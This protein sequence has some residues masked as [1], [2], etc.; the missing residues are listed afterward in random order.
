M[1]PTKTIV[2]SC[3]KTRK[4]EERNAIVSSKCKFCANEWMFY[5]ATKMAHHL[6]SKCKN[7]PNDIKS[8]LAASQGSSTSKS[9][10][11]DREAEEAEER[12][13]ESSRDDGNI[14]SSKSK[15]SKRPLTMSQFLDRIT[16]DEREKLHKLFSRAMV[17]S[18]LPFSTFATPEWEQFFNAL[19]P[20]FDLP[21]EWNL[22][23][24]LLDNQYEEINNK[25]QDQINKTE[26]VCILTD[27]Y[28]NIRN[29]GIMAFIIT[30]PAPLFY[31]MSLPGTE[32]ENSEYV[33]QE[34]SKIIENVGPEKVNGVCTDNAAVMKKTWEIIEEKYP[35]IV[36]YGCSP[37]TLNLLSKDISKL[38][39]IK[40]LL[41]KSQNVVKA[42]K[43]SH[44]PL[45]I[46]TRKQKCAHGANAITLKLPG[47]TRWSGIEEMLNSLYKN[48][49]ELKETVIDSRVKFK[50]ATIRTTVLD[51]EFWELVNS[52]RKLMRP[53]VK[54]IIYLEGDQRTVADVPHVLAILQKEISEVLE[55][56]PLSAIDDVQQIEDFVEKRTAF[57]LKDV[58]FAANFLH[59]L[60]QGMFIYITM[61]NN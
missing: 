48:R 18:N 4:D 45:A 26:N 25:L 32:K 29:E 60:H 20:A 3:F 46:F 58:H 57:G 38:T 9:F 54:S 17:M 55:D 22:R 7:V 49:K 13:L 23:N 52:T 43:R 44:V 1:R 39:S 40:Q 11:Q 47:K 53:I 14:P 21:S 34:L 2:L 51:E 15:P 35:H 8:A 24:S 50:D 27:G 10:V 5:N 12:A 6:V 31:D 28:S 37:H 59:P 42:I 41:R 16:D 33:S 19:R 36:C 56:W 30:T 61:V